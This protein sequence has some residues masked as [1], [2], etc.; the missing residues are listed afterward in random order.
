M[1]FKSKEFLDWDRNT[2]LRVLSLDTLDCNETEVFD[3]CIKWVREE[4]KRMK[5]DETCEE[6]LRIALGDAFFNIRFGLMTLQKFATI[7]KSHPKLFLPAESNEVFYTIANVNDLESSLFKAKPRMKTLASKFL[8]CDI[9]DGSAEFFT[10][11]ICPETSGIRF[12]CDK[13]IILNGFIMCAVPSDNILIQTVHAHIGLKCEST[14]IEN[15]NEEFKVLFKNPFQMLRGQRLGIMIKFQNYVTM[16]VGYKFL[17][18]V[19]HND[20][21]FRLDGLFDDRTVISKLL[22]NK[23]R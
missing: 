12:E 8:S 16:A 9:T 3:A 2:L 7:H 11:A 6:N 19:E 1:I 20:V 17:K 4:C 15:S 18:E 10:S 14:I 13:A 23:L 21:R 5:I 22:Y